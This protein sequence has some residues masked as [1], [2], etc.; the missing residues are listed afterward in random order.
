MFLS[1]SDLSAP[2]PSC[3][4]VQH[5][6]TPMQATFFDSWYDA[7][8]PPM[9]SPLPTPPLSDLAYHAAVT[10]EISDSEAHARTVAS[11]DVAR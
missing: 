10:L 4:H 2:S 7:A 5:A 1:T 9:P 6:V 3:K 8:H 11:L